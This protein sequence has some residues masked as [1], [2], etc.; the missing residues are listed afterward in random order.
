MHYNV[1]IY[2]A[3]KTR[4]EDL[5]DRYVKKIGK[6]L[7]GSLCITSE[8]LQ[9]FKN[10]FDLIIRIRNALESAETTGDLENDA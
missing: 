1:K 7:S 6:Q 5:L 8:E 4:L 9:T 2:Y 10:D 3:D